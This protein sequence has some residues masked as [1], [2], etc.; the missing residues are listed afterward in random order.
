MNSPETQFAP[1]EMAL[2]RD[3]FLHQESVLNIAVGVALEERSEWPKQES[4]RAYMYA[5]IDLAAEAGYTIDNLEAIYL[6]ERARDKIVT[7]DQ[8]QSNDADGTWDENGDRIDYENADKT[9]EQ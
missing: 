8:F 6:L 9:G 3:A 4:P 2:E 1:P 7:D 5:V